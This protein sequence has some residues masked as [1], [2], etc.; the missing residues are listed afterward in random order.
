MQ[1]FTSYF[2]AQTVEVFL[3]VFHRSQSPVL[4]V[5]AKSLTLCFPSHETL[6]KT[7]IAGGTLKNYFWQHFLLLQ[8]PAE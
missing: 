2:K 3:H 4:I 8:A 7:L 5:V 6:G 1:H